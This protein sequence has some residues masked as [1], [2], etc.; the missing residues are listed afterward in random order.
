M[1]GRTRCSRRARTKSSSRITPRE[2]GTQR[3]SHTPGFEATRYPCVLVWGP[4]PRSELLP[5]LSDYE[6]VE[7]AVTHLDQAFMIRRS[8]DE[9]EMPRSTADTA[10]TTRL[11]MPL[12]TRS[13]PTTPSTRSTAPAS[14]AGRTE[15]PTGRP[16]PDAGQCSWPG[17]R[18]IARP[19]A[20]LPSTCSRPTTVRGANRSR[21]IPRQRAGL[22]PSLMALRGSAVRC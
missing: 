22:N 10:S 20:S 6:A 5:V 11:M 14:T 8:A 3:F 17:S 1:T 21:G 19:G 16:V 4:G 9:F 12:G 7:D 13:A 18:A 2:P 15:S